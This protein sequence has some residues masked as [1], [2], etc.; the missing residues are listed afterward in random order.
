MSPSALDVFV[1]SDS[2]C[3]R[4]DDTTRSH[5]TLEFDIAILCL[6]YRREW[7]KATL[8]VQNFLVVG[9]VRINEG[10]HLVSGKKLDCF[11]GTIFKRKFFG[12]K[13]HGKL[14]IPVRRI[15]ILIIYD[16][17]F[18][19]PLDIAISARTRSRST[20]WSMM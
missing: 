5:A 19:Y 8:A 18:L 1:E 9:S 20:K 11:Y 2:Y 17:V 12:D 7:V 4:I 13:G 14:H 10:N 15:R 16:V 6:E 3:Q